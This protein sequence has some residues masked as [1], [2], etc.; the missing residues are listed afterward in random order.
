VE[1]FKTRVRNAV[2]FLNNNAEMK[3]KMGNAVRSM[4]RRLAECT[5]KKGARTNY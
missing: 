2:R 3:E 4:P 1:E 5:Q